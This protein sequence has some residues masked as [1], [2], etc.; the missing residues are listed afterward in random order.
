MK[1]K[2][3]VPAAPRSDTGGAD[4]PRE[5]DVIRIEDLAPRTDVTGGR[6]IL[7]GEMLTPVS[8]PLIRPE[9]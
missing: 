9:S 4:A 6:K 3:E 5:D 2:R 1:E 8:S 7:L